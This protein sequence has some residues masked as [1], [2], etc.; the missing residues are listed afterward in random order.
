MDEPIYRA[1]A[2]W[3]RRADGR[4]IYWNVRRDSWDHHPYGPPAVP[5]RSAAQGYETSRPVPGYVPRDG[6]RP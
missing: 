6:P 4:W 3:L 2:W 1:G 5:A